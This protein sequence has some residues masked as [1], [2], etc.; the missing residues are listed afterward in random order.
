MTPAKEGLQWYVSADL[1]GVCGVTSPS[2]VFPQKPEHYTAYHRAVSQLAMELA[3]I[4]QP[5]LQNP[6]VDEILINDAHA[7]MTNLWLDHGPLS[8]P[9]VHFVS[10]KPKPI[11]M[12]AG[13]QPHHDALVFVGYHAK[14]STQNGTLCHS[15]HTAITD[16]QLNGVSVGEGGFNAA[17]AWF[18]HQIPLA[19]ACGDDAFCREIKALIPSVQT[20]ETKKA[21]GFSAAETH[22]VEWVQQEMTHA[23]RDL[24]QQG[25]VAKET[26][27]LE[28]LSAKN[29]W[30]L[31]LTFQTPLQADV[32]S[33]LPMVER[34]DGL[35]I[36]VQSPDIETAYRYLQSLY[37]LLAYELTLG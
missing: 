9:K 16:L 15:F 21:M 30:T 6:Y 3:W 17:Y 37:S 1:E 5:A 8:H 19:I 14:A 4:L 2:Q 32:V 11:A 31:K 10:G 27:T 34:L 33:I 13:L 22:P 26:Y 24:I 36:Q 18:Q 7:R 12:L 29:G 20:V 28:G 35:S 25:G 23:M